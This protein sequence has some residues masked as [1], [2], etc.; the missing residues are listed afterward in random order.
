[1]KCRHCII[2]VIMKQACI[3]PRCTSNRRTPSHQFPKDPGRRL[4]WLKNIK[5][6][7]IEHIISEARNNIRIC[8]KHFS[9]EDYIYSIHRRKLKDDAVPHH[10]IP[11]M[12]CIAA[13]NNI[14]YH[15]ASPSMCTFDLNPDMI[16]LE[17]LQPESVNKNIRH[18]TYLQEVNVETYYLLYL[19]NF[20][21]S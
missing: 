4:L 19:Y 14:N 8:Y 13:S 10:N 9:E 1:M 20:Y 6:Q 12:K 3:V 15:Q 21:Y 17:L 16:A 7:N 2:L 5:L 18:A 11:E